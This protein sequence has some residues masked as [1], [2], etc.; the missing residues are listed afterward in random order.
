MQNE[1]LFY[2]IIFGVVVTVLLRKMVKNRLFQRAVNAPF[3]KSWLG[4]LESKLPVYP[5]LTP[6][7]QLELQQRVKEF[8][9]E[10]KFEGCGG[11]E[12]NDEIRITI[13]GE[14]CLLILDRPSTRYKKLKWI[15]VYPST[16]IAKREVADAYG[17]VSEGRS[18][19]LGESWSHGR[20]ILAWDSVERGIKNTDDGQ[21][22]VLHEFAHQLDQEDGRADGAPLLYT[23]DSYQIWSQVF[24]DEFDTLQKKLARGAKTL[25]DSYGATNPAEFFAVVTELY[26]ECPSKLKHKH[27]ELFEALKQYYRVDPRKWE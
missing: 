22:V 17:V 4:I 3:P 14:A 7:L 19:L 21:N 8:L 18:F 13:A 20:V 10:K 12:M 26:F 9:F 27:P 25:I 16:F 11:L 24:S 5:K 2:L 1:T 6:E 23:K 15:Y